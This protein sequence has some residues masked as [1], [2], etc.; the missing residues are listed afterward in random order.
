MMERP[1]PF[2]ICGINLRKADLDYMVCMIKCDSVFRQFTW[3]G[4]ARGSEYLIVNGHSIQ[5]F[6]GSDAAMIPWSSLRRGYIIESHRRLQHHREGLPATSRAA[7]RR[8]S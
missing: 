6:S 2:D 8:S 1:E 7:R 4:G 3:H 5:V